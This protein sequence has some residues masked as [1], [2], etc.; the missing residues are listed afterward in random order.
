[1]PWK[2]DEIVCS[3]EVYQEVPLDLWLELIPSVQVAH[4]QVCPEPD[5]LSQSPD[6]PFSLDSFGRPEVENSI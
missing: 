5:P 6:R 1:M 3:E 2:I 4:Y